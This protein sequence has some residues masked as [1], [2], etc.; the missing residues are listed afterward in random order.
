MT[1]SLPHTQTT[2]LTAKQHPSVLLV[3][4]AVFCVCTA[5]GIWAVVFSS[6]QQRYAAEELALKHVLNQGDSFEVE[7]QRAFLP[8]RT[9]STFIGLVRQLLCTTFLQAFVLEYQASYALLY[10][11]VCWH[12][13]HCKTG[14]S[15]DTCV[16]LCSACMPQCNT[17][18]SICPIAPVGTIG[19]VGFECVPGSPSA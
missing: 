9:L 14:K 19:L 16:W 1:S 8:A 10:T 5:L 2:W 4:I 6:Q 18:A 13:T 12:N 17:L 3:P 11:Y 15:C 7:M